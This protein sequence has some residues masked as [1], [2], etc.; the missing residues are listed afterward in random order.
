MTVHYPDDEALRRIGEGVLA[1]SLPKPEWTHAAHFACTL[2]LMRHRPD[3]DLPERMPGIIRAYNV[4][5]GGENT[6]SAGYHETITQASLRAARSVFEAHPASEPLHEALD[7]LM[8]GPF[9]DKDWLLSYWTRARLFS[10]EA[11]RGWVEPD[12]APLPW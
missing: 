9:G 6:D 1:L 8:A 11:R 3:L 5:V 10:V 12:I 7:A 4:S 2:W